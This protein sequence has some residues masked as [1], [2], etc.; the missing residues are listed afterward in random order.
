MVF[1]CVWCRTDLCHGEG[2]TIYCCV[3]S[4][5]VIG[6]LQPN[7]HTPPVLMFIIALEVYRGISSIIP[8]LCTGTWRDLFVWLRFCFLNSSSTN[9]DFV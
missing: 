4:S 2:C 1:H 5:V 7:L 8:K 3:D 6:W 9:T